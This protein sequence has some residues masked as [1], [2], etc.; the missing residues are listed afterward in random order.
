MPVFED[1]WAYRN[2]EHGIYTYNVASPK[3]AGGHLSDNQWVIV[4]R[5]ANNVQIEDYDIVGSSEVFKDH[6]VM[7]SRVFTWCPGFG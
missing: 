7:R 2:R 3:W 5:A 1:M 4:L 6:T